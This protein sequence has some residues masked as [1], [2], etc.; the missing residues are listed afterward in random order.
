MPGTRPGMTN[1]GHCPSARHLRLHLIPPGTDAG[2]AI[3][4]ALQHLHRLAQARFGGFDAELTRLLALLRRHP[5]AVVAPQARAV[6]ALE[7][8]PAVVIDHLAAPAVL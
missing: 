7:R 5:F 1:D 4:V 2:H 3:V 6:L 8:L